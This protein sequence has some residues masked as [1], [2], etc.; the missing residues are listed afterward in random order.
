[1]KHEV[2]LETPSQPSVIQGCWAS[3][4]KEFMLDHTRLLANIQSVFVS[5]HVLGNSC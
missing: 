5:C 1:M 4:A 2:W 3:M